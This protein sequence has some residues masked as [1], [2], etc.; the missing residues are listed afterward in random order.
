MLT[1]GNGLHA[2]PGG[3][4]AIA[5][6]SF[7]WS[8]GSVLS[9]RGLPLAPGASGFATQL[10]CGGLALLAMSALA[11]EPWHWPAQ[12]GPW[13]AWAYLMTFGSLIAFNAYMLLLARTSPALASSYTLVNPLVALLLGVTLGRESISPWEWA[14][15]GVII[16][17]VALLFKPP[18]GRRPNRQTNP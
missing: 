10:L 16:S 12:S 1:Q 2:S 11:A 5:L 14:A 18:R 8:L 9:Q 13:L 3:V 7:C 6:G 17:G 15:S 4:A